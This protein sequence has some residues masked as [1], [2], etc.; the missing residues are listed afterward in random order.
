MCTDFKAVWVG[1]GDVDDVAG[2]WNDEAVVDSCA[3]QERG[4]G[5]D[6]SIRMLRE[7]ELGEQEADAPNG[8]ER[9]RNELILQF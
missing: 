8:F 1:I 7:Q 5:G 2:M 9:R 4:T 6:S 3:E